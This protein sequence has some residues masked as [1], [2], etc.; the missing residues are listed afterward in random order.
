MLAFLQVDGLLKIFKI[1]ENNPAPQ[2][3]KTLSGFRADMKANFQ[4]S[5]KENVLAVLY[6][7]EYLRVYE[8]ENWTIKSEMSIQNCLNFELISK[9]AAFL[10]FSTG[11]MA[12]YS[13]ERNQIISTANYQGGDEK[14]FENCSIAICNEN[15][16]SIFDPKRSDLFLIKI[17]INSNDL[18]K[19]EDKNMKLSKLS[20][21]ESSKSSKI[22]KTKK[23]LFAKE[24]ESDTGSGHE[25][26]HESGQEDDSVNEYGSENDH[27]S[28]MEGSEDE[29]M[30]FES[31]NRQ[32]SE[33]VRKL[34]P[35]IQ[36]CCTPWRNHQH[37]LAYNNVGFITARR[38]LDQD[39][40]VFN[41]DIEFMD[42]SAHQ[43]IR[44]SN[45]ISFK[46]ASLSEKGAIFVSDGAGAGLHYVPFDSPTETWNVPLSLGTEPIR[47]LF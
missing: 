46:A 5:W 18:I 47:T 17:K 7:G 45:E 12:I 41:Y 32:E 39:K 25:S 44:F 6:G 36:P 26:D 1:V 29:N 16:A 34:H 13:I 23:G 20:R 2:L 35:V 4:L 15:F 30:G 28:D 14:E 42:R 19:V 3:I 8:A 9:E 31:D 24:E 27:N 22:K 38:S 33:L 10:T 43:P 11:E 40:T 37:Y 21:N